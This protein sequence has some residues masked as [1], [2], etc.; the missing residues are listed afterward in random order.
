MVL[1][2][3][4]LVALVC[5]ALGL[6]LASAAWLI[7]SLVISAVAALVLWR[8]RAQ[9]IGGARKPQ[10]A[11]STRA[12]TELAPDSEVWVIDGR[13]RY[14][15]G[16][17]TRIAGQDAEAIPYRQAVEDGFV[18]CP[19]C[20]PAQVGPAAATAAPDAAGEQSGG[21]AADTA[22]QGQVWV[23]D[24]RPRYH[25]ATCMIIEGQQAERIPLTQATE[26]GFM[27]CSLCGSARSG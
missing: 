16:E 26:D 22:E 27:P 4:L 3:L 23:V 6:V 8:V 7:A 5:L 12:A 1:I 11:E 21:P 19:S 2:A 20:L 17:C 9:L 10:S 15:L 24:G 25:Q 14:H 18:A 13:P